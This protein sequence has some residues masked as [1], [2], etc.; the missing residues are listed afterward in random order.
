[1][2]KPLKVSPKY[3]PA[4]GLLTANAKMTTIFIQMGTAVAPS[5]AALALLR[6]PDAPEKK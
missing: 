1:L 5:T 3:I 2:T 6:P 4:R